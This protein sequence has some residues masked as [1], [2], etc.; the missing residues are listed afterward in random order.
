MAKVG[1]PPVLRVG[2]QG[3]EV[4]LEALIVELLELLGVVEVGAEGVLSG[5]MLAQDVYPE[6]VWPPVCVPRAGTSDI[7]HLDGTLAFGHDGWMQS[8]VVGGEE[9]GA[10]SCREASGR[11]V[12]GA[13]K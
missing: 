8:C 13:Y 10:S 5:V 6:L 9:D 7:G 1:R 4:L 11:A 3:S 2:H 12:F